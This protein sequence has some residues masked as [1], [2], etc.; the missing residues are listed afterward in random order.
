MEKPAPESFAP[1]VEKNEQVDVTLAISGDKQ[2]PVRISLGIYAIKWLI[3]K[4]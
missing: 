3:F 4:N 1:P 2:A